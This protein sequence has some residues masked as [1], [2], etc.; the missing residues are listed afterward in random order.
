MCV[1]KRNG[2]ADKEDK[3]VVTSGEREEGGER[4][5]EGGVRGTDY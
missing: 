5:G 3:P 4:C 1:A 2:L